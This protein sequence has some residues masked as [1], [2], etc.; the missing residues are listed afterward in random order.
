VSAVIVVG[1]GPIGLASAILFAREGHEVI[2][3]EKDPQP[4]PATAIGAWEDWER[5]GVAQFRQVH[6]IQA[7]VRHIVDA[8]F[9]EVLDEINAAG[10]RRVNLAKGFFAE[11]GDPSSL[12]GDERFE[13]IAARRPVVESAFARVAENT[14]GVKVVRGV[15]VEGP[16]VDESSTNGIP[17]VVG[18]RTK[19]GQTYRGDLVVDAGGRR[20][21]FVDW[22]T[23]IGGRAP[24]EEASDTGFAYYTRYYRCRDGFEPELRRAPFTFLSTFSTITLPADNETW[25]VGVIAMAGDKPMKA[26]RN[27]E[28]WERVVRSVPH[29]GHWVEGDP[30]TDVLPMA[31]AMDRYRRFVVDGTPVVTG[32]VAIGDAWACTNPTA[33]RGISLGLAHAVALRDL[34]RTSFDDPYALAMALDSVTEEKLTPWYRQ[35]YDRD[36]ARVA[37]IDAAIEGREPP[38]IDESNPI[39]RIQRAFQIAAANDPECARAFAEMLSVL[40]LPQEIMARP[41]MFEKIM[42]TAEGKEL[43][44]MSGPTRTELLALLGSA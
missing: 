17:H 15:S 11:M 9:P 22:V 33:G 40:T 44:A 25:S 31:G 39:A 3:L 14:A 37:Q 16:I 4:A 12:P 41:G 28:V 10:G 8:E 30:I 13:T 24:I 34:S 7:R 32:M 36:R 29:M 6:G 19:D 23:G 18:V 43:P 20:S 21:K 26:L 27:S 35:Q 1:G 2:V 38:P 5:S 42:A